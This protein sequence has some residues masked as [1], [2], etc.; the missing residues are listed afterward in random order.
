MQN[1]ARTGESDMTKMQMLNSEKPVREGFKNIFALTSN[2]NSLDVTQKETQQS[3]QDCFEV[4]EK[5]RTG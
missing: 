3:S 2:E 5:I 1:N 4:H